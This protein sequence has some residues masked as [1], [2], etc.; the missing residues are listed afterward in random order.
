ML[1][2]LPFVLRWVNVLLEGWLDRCARDGIVTV[3]TGV[4]PPNMV[5]VET[6][7]GECVGIFL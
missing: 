7:E 4:M 5:L 1:L 6:E 3:C 2:E